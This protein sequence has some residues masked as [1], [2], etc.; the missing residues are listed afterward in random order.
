VLLLVACRVP[1]SVQ[2]TVKFGL[3]APFEGRYRYVGYDLFPAVRLA[4]REANMAGGVEGV[5]VELVAYDDGADPGMAVQ[6][7]HKLAVDQQVVA[8][9]GH[10]RESTTA[11][12]A[13][14][15]A[16]ID[17]PLVCVTS[18]ARSGPTFPLGPDLEALASAMLEGVE[19][20]AVVSDGGPLSQSLQVVAR[21]QG[22]ELRP[23][24]SLDTPGW[25]GAV[26]A[27]GP[28]VVLC[29]AD[30]VPAAEAAAALR[31]AGWAGR[32]VGGPALAAADFAAVAGGASE[33]VEFV[34]PWP[35]PQDVDPAGAFTTA[36]T[37]VSGGT[38]PGPL[39]LPAYRAARLLLEAL[40][41]NLAAEGRPSRAGMA[42]ALAKLAEDR[43]APA[44]P[45]Y[46]Y[47]IGADGAMEMVQLVR[48]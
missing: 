20:A 45:I 47:R 39:A 21:R 46:R 37:E 16:V 36:Y 48:P 30:P 15:Y 27:S 6:Q 44:G 26:A 35:F 19:A 11:A 34:T 33:G 31:S 18:L 41:V 1:G 23:I 14:T 43:H 32:F 4:L 38:P 7:A 29:D 42:S 5:F 40:Q 13:P 10:F 24:V 22:V 2:P 28:G 17:L 8:V 25:P 3:V 9:L 12:A